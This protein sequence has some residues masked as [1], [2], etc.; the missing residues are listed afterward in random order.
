[1]SKK[2]HFFKAKSKLGAIY[3]L[4]R[5]DHYISGVEDGPDY[6]LTP[7]L[8]EKF[9]EAQVSEYIFSSP[10]GVSEKDYYPLLAKELAEFAD[11]I[12]SE[13]KK[14]E[15][16]VVIGGDNT[17]TFSSLLAL[18]RRAKSV[19]DIGYVQFDS[20]GEMHLYESSISKN[21]HGMYMRP[22][23]DKFD[24]E[25]IEKMVPEKLS[26]SQA[27]TIGDIIFDE[28]DNHPA[29]EVQLYKE[30]RNVRRAEFLQNKEQVLREFESFTH[31]FKHL[32]VNFDIDV[33][34]GSVAGATGENEGV[35]FWK[36]VDQFLEIIKKHPNVS[37]DLVEINPHLDK[38]KRTLRIAHKILMKI[39]N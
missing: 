8:L 32:F 19:K 24:I 35:W 16:Q 12:T 23:F 3:K 34:D 26:L 15:T 37:L 21:F 5:Q 22:F 31:R 28:G 14:G 30:I 39:L 4:M 13:T 18:T 38:S 6:I 2:P 29:G 20:H 10:E 7:K 25:N 33:F 17:V 27:F 11:L 9:P 36:E 1:M